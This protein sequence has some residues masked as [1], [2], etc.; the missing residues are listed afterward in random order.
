M[1]QGVRNR[2]RF[3]ARHVPSTSSVN[4]GWRAFQ[5]GLMG[6]CEASTCVQNGRVLSVLQGQAQPEAAFCTSQAVTN[7]TIPRA[8]SFPNPVLLRRNNNYKTQTVC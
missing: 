2:L 6:P 7:I 5:L 1:P 4:V 3:R 8:L